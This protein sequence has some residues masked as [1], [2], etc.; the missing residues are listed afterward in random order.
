MDIQN[1]FT[2]QD[3][4]YY[5]ESRFRMIIF[6][7]DKLQ[8]GSG[9]CPKWFDSCLQEELVSHNFVLIIIILWR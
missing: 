7:M 1:H 9:K 5:A 3:L 8:K 6:A 2:I 4:V